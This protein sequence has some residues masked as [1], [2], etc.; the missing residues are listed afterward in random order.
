MNK[1]PSSCIL[2]FASYGAILCLAGDPKTTPPPAQAGEPA[3]MEKKAADRPVRLSLPREIH[4]VPGVE[5]NVYFDN[6][7]LAPNIRGC[8][9]DVDCK[10]GRHDQDRWTYVPEDKDAG[11]FP[12]TVKVF[13][14]NERLLAEATTTV[15]VP[16]KDAGKDQALTLLMVGDSLTA[17]SVYPAELHRMLSMPENPKVTFIGSHSGRGRPPGEGVPLHEG[18]GG[19]AWSTFCAKYDKKAPTPPGTSPFV[20]LKD[21][22]PGLDFK[23]YCD[24]KNNGKA[25]DY[26]TVFLGTNDTFGAKDA[27]IEQTIDKMFQYADTLIAE[28]RKV[29]PKTKIGI[30]LVHPPCASQD[31]FGNNYKCGQTRWQY[32]KNQH[33]AVERL[34]EKFAGREKEGLFIIPLNVNLD[35]ANNYPKEEKPVNARNPRKIMRDC[36]GVHPATEGYNQIA[37]SFY[38]WL[39]YMLS[40]KQ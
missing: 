8:L 2:L 11:N 26:I 5:M 33:R 28:F 3:P 35:C 30:A 15:Y 29:G 6:I 34:L 31:G 40:R 16:P 1:F 24:R 13:D 20:F 36:N 12:L 22:K 18:Y 38:C 7:V 9:F 10:F 23:A 25:P 37:D 27:T 19:W 32:R 17:A 14:T 4:A 21:G 39:K